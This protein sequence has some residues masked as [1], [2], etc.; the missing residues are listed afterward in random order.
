MSISRLAWDL[1]LLKDLRREILAVRDVETGE[2]AKGDVLL[3]L[4]ADG[5]ELSYQLEHNVSEMSVQLPRNIMQ[6]EAVYLNV[7]APGYLDSTI[8]LSAKAKTDAE[9]S[10][11]AF[12]GKTS[13]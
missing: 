1:K 2:A 10:L 3:I 9:V 13:R 4:L 11:E 7:T 12:L 6:A 8:L 5:N